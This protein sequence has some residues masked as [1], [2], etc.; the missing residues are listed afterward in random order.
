MHFPTTKWWPWEEVEHWML[1]QNFHNHLDKSN[2]IISVLVKLSSR[3]LAWLS[4]YWLDNNNRLLHLIHGSWL[5]HLKF[6]TFWKL[7]HLKRC[8]R[9]PGHEAGRSEP[10]LTWLL[11]LGHVCD[12]QQLN[13]LRTC[14]WRLNLLELLAIITFSWNSSI[15][16]NIGGASRLSPEKIN[17]VTN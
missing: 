15:I 17:Y 10:H 16:I 6:H 14:V 8:E 7:W 1:C 2:Y 9:I 3:A 4:K 11:K 13:V 5:G 12:P